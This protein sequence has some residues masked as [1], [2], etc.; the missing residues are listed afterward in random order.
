MSDRAPDA[1]VVGDRA[2]SV[3][4]ARSLYSARAVLAAAYK[5][6]DF[7]V[8]L[9]NDDGPDRWLLSVIAKPGEEGAATLPRLIRELTDQALRDQ[10]ERE[11]GAIRTLV[12]AQAFAEGNLLES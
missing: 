7:A 12:V 11:F 3:S 4:V 6:S 5:L 8:I 2:G 9:V 10:L 1:W